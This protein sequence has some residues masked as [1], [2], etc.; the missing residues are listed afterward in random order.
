MDPLRRQTG[1]PREAV[2]ER[3]IESFRTRYGLTQGKVTDEELARAQ[4][5]ARTKFTAPE[6][7][8]RVP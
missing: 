5:L 7:V 1:L 6:W 8:A 3:M 4:E 2:I